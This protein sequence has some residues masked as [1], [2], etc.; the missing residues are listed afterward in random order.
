[1]LGEIIRLQLGRIG[2]RVEESRDV[3]FTYD[4]AVVDL[5]PAAAAS[6]SRAEGG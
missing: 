2:R 3:P 6:S 4:D 1:M 5:D